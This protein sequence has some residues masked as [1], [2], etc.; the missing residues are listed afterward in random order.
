M[1]DESISRK[2]LIRKLRALGYFGPLSGG[3]HQFMIKG[4]KKIRIPDPHKG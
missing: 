4:E 3:K 1:P 2:V